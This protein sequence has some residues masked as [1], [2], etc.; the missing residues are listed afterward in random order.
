[1]GIAVCAKSLDA[2]WKGRQALDVK[3]DK[4]ILPQMDNDFIEKT[5]MDGIG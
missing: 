4:G 2:A 3:W 5:F 1:M